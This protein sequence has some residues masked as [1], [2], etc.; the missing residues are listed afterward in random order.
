[1][2]DSRTPYI[3]EMDRI[4]TSK[5]AAGVRGVRLF[6]RDGGDVTSEDI[7]RGYCKMCKAEGDGKFEDVTDEVL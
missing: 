2:V 3:A 7:A 5:R 6:V 1:M 4:L